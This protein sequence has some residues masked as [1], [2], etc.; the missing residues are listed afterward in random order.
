MNGTGIDEDNSICGNSVGAIVKTNS[1]WGR[2]GRPPNDW[3]DSIQAGGLID[4]G[5]SMSGKQGG[6]VILVRPFPWWAGAKDLVQVSLEGLLDVWMTG[7][8][9]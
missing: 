8:E 6:E 3:Q 5:T 7:Q 1:L 9:C 2:A 4:D